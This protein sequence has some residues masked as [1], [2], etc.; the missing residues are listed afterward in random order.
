MMSVSMFSRYSGAAMP[1]MTLTGV[2]TSAFV[3]R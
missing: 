3:D 2:I 1:S